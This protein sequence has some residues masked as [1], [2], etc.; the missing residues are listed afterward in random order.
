MYNEFI[1]VENK[2][3]LNIENFTWGN[4]MLSKNDISQQLISIS[5]EE[6]EYNSNLYNTEV[7]RIQNLPDEEV[8]PDVIE[9]DDNGNE[10]PK[11]SKDEM[12]AEY[13]ET[14]KQGLLDKGYVLGKDI[15]VIIHE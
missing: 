3:L 10:I 2:V 13:A 8:N 11:K 15:E 14:L 4:K 1:T 6:A 7:E 5:K 9:I 12:I